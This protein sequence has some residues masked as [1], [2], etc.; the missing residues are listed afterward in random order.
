MTKM[1]PKEWNKTKKCLHERIYHHFE[2]NRRECRNRKSVHWRTERI[3]GRLTDAPHAQQNIVLYVYFSGTAHR[4]NE[5]IRN[6]NEMRK[7]WE[8]KKMKTN[9][10]MFERTILKSAPICLLILR[11]RW[12][13]DSA[14]WFYDQ[15]RLRR[16]WRA[17]RR[18][19]FF[20]TFKK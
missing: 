17:R 18:D 6:K 9:L 13:V 1:H 12:V 16:R 19:N 3:E 11:M 14:T 5:F 4:I 10:W 20:S 15:M 8:K 7:K 2:C